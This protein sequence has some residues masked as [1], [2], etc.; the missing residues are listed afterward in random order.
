MEQHS[1]IEHAAA[2]LAVHLTRAEAPGAVQAVGPFVTISRETGTGGSE[3]A[4]AVLGRL[5]CPPAKE[6][7]A[8]YSGNLIEEMLRAH[9]LPRYL[10]RFLPED[11][12]SF[13][14]ASV[15]ELVGLHPDLWDLVAKTNELMRRLARAG[16]AI[17]LGRGANF[18]TADV[19]RGV[20]VRLVASAE[21]RA[22]RTA[23]ALSM[24]PEAAL[25]HNALRDAARRRYVRTTFG[26]DISDPVHYHLLLNAEHLTPEKMVVLITELV[27]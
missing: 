13:L 12:I 22:A 7:W 26:K 6:P 15:G 18:A 5:R 21:Y 10:D 17:L 2:Y 20:H 25:A 4:R 3:L 24:S 8:I 9:N 27:S 1:H 23:H 11:R 19:P 16:G 14:E